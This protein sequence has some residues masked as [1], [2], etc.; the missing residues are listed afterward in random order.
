MA[1]CITARTSTGETSLFYKQSETHTKLCR[2]QETHEQNVL[3]ADETYEDGGH[4]QEEQETGEA[5]LATFV[6]I[7]DYDHNNG[8]D[9]EW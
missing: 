7:E 4:D 3:P 5:S 8:S 2:E 9:K 1:L 6:T